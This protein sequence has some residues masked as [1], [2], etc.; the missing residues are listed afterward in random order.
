[1]I[2]HRGAPTF[3]IDNPTIV[4]PFYVI[5]VGEGS[6]VSTMSYGCAASGYLTA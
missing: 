1:M 3:M 6:G 5:S 2:E 4:L